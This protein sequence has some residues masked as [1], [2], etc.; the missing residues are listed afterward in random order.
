MR[1]MPLDHEMVSI[2]E[3]D[4][5]EAASITLEGAEALIPASP[6]RSS[7]GSSRRITIAL[8]FLIGCVTLLMTGF[9]IIMPVFPQRLH[10]LGLGAETLALMEGAFGLGMFLLSTPMGIWAG[11]IGRK[12]ILFI[13]LAGFIATNLLFLVVNVPIL[14]ILIRFGEG[15][16]ISGLMPAAMAMVGDTIPEEKQGRWI[17]FLT[18]AQATGIALGPGIGGFLYQ[19]LGFT[20][21]FLLSA[22]IALAASLLALFLV[23]ET[24]PAHVRE[25]ARKPKTK[26]ARAKS[27]ELSM[28]GLIWLFAPFLVIDFGLIFTYPFVFPQYP[29]FFERVLHYSTAQYGL[30]ISVFGLALAV[31]PIVLG[32]LTERWPKKPLIVVGSLLFGLLNACMFAAPSYPLLI[33]GS[34]LTGVGSALASP[35]LGGIYLSATTDANRGQVMG[36]RGSAISAAVM[37]G[38][39]AQ[40]VISPWVNPQTTFAIGMILS[41]GMT[42]VAFF[43]VKRPR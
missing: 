30:I 16:L 37:L 31:S 3:E 41:L 9:A 1:T 13:S 21:P 12:P 4:E 39:L 26:E 36:I 29:F 14:F 7:V 22:S 5:R 28:V 42:V 17:G 40:A 15:L 33:V 20:G 35:A 18:T 25:E 24:L 43:L 19:A 2:T 11:R 27:Q 32:R 34:A 8:T 23:P 6:A 10:S 38:P